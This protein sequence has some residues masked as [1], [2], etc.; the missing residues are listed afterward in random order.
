MS[1]ATCYS[2]SN[3]VYFD[4]PPMM[5]DGRVFEEHKTESQ[6]MH[7]NMIKDNSIR[8]NADYRKYLANNAD[9]IISYNQVE[10]YHQTGFKPVVFQNEPSSNAPYLFKSK[11][12]PTKP[13]GY[14]DSDLKK[15]YLT[16]EQLQSQL[17]APVIDI[18]SK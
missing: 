1:W 12:D 2:S 17:T 4:L 9:S 3:N 7:Q 14:N 10:S 11:S 18:S 16:R 8:T 15:K 5:D 13:V 6:I